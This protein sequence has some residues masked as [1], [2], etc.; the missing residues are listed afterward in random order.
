MTQRD[1][2]LLE[3]MHFTGFHGTRPEE[4]TLGQR[5]VV[6][7]ELFC[8][9]RAAG[10]RDDLHASVDY[11]EVYATTR[12]IVEGEPVNLTETVAERI[13]SAILREQPKVEAVRVAVRKP[14]VR[15]GDTVLDGSVVQIF[16]QRPGKPL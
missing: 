4:R 13:A 14:F 9:L 6:D 11:S 16:R 3:G 5:F 1:S 10:E 12:T 2:I 7:V 15:L 8:D